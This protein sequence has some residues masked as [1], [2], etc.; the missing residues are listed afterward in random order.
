ARTTVFAFDKTGT[1]TRGRPK[2]S[3]VR[4]FECAH[5]EAHLTECAPCDEIV[6]LAASDARAW[7]HPSAR[8]VVDAAEKRRVGQ[9]YPHDGDITSHTGRGVSG[10][11]NGRRM[12]AGNASLFAELEHFDELVAAQHPSSGLVFAG[13]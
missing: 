2:V 10:T 4:S 9:G 13:E 6:A 8:A 7:A 12:T 5:T 11:L 3:G 1:L